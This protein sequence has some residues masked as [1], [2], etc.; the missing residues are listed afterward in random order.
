MGLTVQLPLVFWDKMG[1]I[2]ILVKGYIYLSIYL[3]IH[4]HVIRSTISLGSNSVASLRGYNTFL[5]HKKMI[6]NLKVVAN[7]YFEFLHPE[8]IQ[9][10]FI[11]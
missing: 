2:S 11:R 10:T 8:A 6:P 4:F 5:I 1:D 7:I 9:Y 3:D